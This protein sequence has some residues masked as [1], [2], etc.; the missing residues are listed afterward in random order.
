MAGSGDAHAR[1]TG[2]G[3]LKNLLARLVL[4]QRMAEG[5]VCRLGGD[6]VADQIY[7]GKAAHGRH[8][9]QG[10]F[11]GRVA[12]RT[13]QL[14]QADLQHGG[15]W[16]IH[17]PSSLPAGFGVVGS[18]KSISACQCSAASISDRKLSRLVCLLAV[19]R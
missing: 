11:H 10:L 18:I 5:Q 16:M 19:V 2:S 4:L 7:T 12:E 13:T 15:E 3:G 17:R 14:Q 8:L 9:D 1:F 6:P